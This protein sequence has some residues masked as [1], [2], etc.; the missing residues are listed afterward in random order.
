MIT[1]IEVF[2]RRIRRVFSRSELAIRLLR[3]PKLE[4]PT[5]EPGLVMIQI[6]GLSFTQFNRAVEKGN[7]PF[8]KSL[9]CQE[10]YVMHS[11]YS[12]LP[13]NT[14][15]VQAE[16]FY[17]VKG[18]VCA[19]HFVDRPTGQSIKMLDAHY[20]EKFEPT[21]KE[22]GGPGLLSGGSAYSNIYTGGA[23]EGHFC[24]SKLG[25]GGVLHAAN[26]LVLPF[27]AILYIDIF[28]RT[29]ILLVLEFF[30]ASFACIRGI[31]QGRFISEEFRFVWLRVMICVV[32]RE[33]IVA[34]AC[35]DIMRGLP[36]I[37]L[38]FLGYDEQAHCRG[39]YS[40][41][42]HWALQGIDNSIRRI[43]NVITQSPY[44]DYD[45]WVYADH[46]QERTIPYYVKYG[47]TPEEAIEKL[48]GGTEIPRELSLVKRHQ[49]RDPHAMISGDKKST[50]SQRENP[51]CY[52]GQ[53]V[54]TTAMGPLGHVYVKRNLHK[55]E[56]EYYGRKLV[57]EL[58]IPLVMIRKDTEKAIAFT[59]RGSFV[60]PDQAAEVFGEDHPFIEEIKEDIMR[61][62]FHPN[63]GEFIIA[64]WCKGETP[65]SF[66]LE[67]GAHAGMGPEETKAFV[68]LPMDAPLKP[69]TKT[70]LRPADLGEAAR[71]HLNGESSYAFGAAAETAVDKP[72]RVVSYNVHG[73]L[74][75]DG[76]IST[77]RIARVIARHNPDV[78]CMQELDSGRP[79]SRRIDQI[80]RI[81]KILEMKFHFHPAYHWE[82]EQ[83]GN[84]IL[85]RYPMALIKMGPLPRLA[86]K[87]RFEP[88]GAM[89]VAVEFQGAV[90]NIINTHLSIWP[91]E[92]ILQT[93]ALLSEE[94]LAHDDCYGPVVLCG[95]FNSL[96][97]SLVYRKICQRLADSQA[98]LEG[99]TPY[100][101]WFGHYP[102]GQIDHIFVT[103]DF[104][105]DAISVP[106]TMLDKVASDH[107]PL[108]VDVK[109]KPAMQ[110]HMV[111]RKV[112]HPGG[113]I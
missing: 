59:P 93:N 8:L 26:P 79:R 77:E 37:H 22:K 99:H 66:P 40:R 23:E 71:R 109:L 33:F 1:R 61:I 4:R 9:L 34:G 84:A 27:L 98:I 54:T 87:M 11:F 12:G 18:C 20:V 68:L 88:R 46:G 74:G 92:R 39:P 50:L 62:C 102:V 90:I 67:Y 65:I 36:V 16:L 53:Q 3:L 15:S 113:I 35:M 14:P 45:L 103:P 6:D 76:V 94:W 48:F 21:L 41:Y 57:D 42:A 82:E 7:V 31:L 10:R 81:A 89:W 38:N 29:L 47:R 64:G 60:L 2:L 86:D 91:Q 70:Y 52:S 49:T 85:S 72:L 5:G 111:F 110:S 63:A 104:E 75:I 55:D 96:P 108:I 28:L 106:R 112:E 56:F 17:G 97:G 101:T 100:A 43:Y 69:Q 19:F 83:Y 13:S 73:C 32:L 30:I 107:L 80:D 51:K 105:V 95:D 25:W 58:K 78:V 44:R 24:F